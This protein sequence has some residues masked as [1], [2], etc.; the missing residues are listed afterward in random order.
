MSGKCI[1]VIPCYNEENRLVFEPFINFANSHPCIKFL[2]VNDGSSDKTAERLKA[3]KSQLGSQADV[4]HLSENHGKAEAVRQGIV[5]ACDDAQLDYFGYWDAD[6]STPLEAID[7]FLM[8]LR[9]RP[10]AL[11]VF[12]ARVLLLGRTITRSP[13]RHYLGRVFATFASI[14]L[15]L[16]IYD[17]QCGAKIFRHTQ[18]TQH[19]FSQPFLSRW[20]FDVEI[21]ARL[22]RN[23]A[24]ETVIEHPLQQ[25]I[26]QE[27][28]KLRPSDFLRAPLELAVIFFKYR[29]ADF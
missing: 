17:T 15:N 29:K 21:L 13:I 19:L 11:I 5:T 16:A 22:G 24:S 10:N 25:W 7:E 9:D 1:I 27:Q 26:N 28:S 14:A 4:L 8:L 18:Q 3:L 6:L 23:T 2:F 20:L 12:G